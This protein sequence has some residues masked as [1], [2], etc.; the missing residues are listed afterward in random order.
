MVYICRFEAAD[1]SGGR[2]CSSKAG[3]VYENH[4]LIQ[5]G[6]RLKK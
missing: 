2:L 5:S 1:L 3:Q 6:E 4:H